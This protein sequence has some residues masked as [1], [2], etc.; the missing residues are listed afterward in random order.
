MMKLLQ[1]I[2]RIISESSFIGICYPDVS[3][4]GYAIRK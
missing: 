1:K 4:G 2:K 3:N